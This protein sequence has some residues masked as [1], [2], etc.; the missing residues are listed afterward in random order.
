MLLVRVAAVVVVTLVVTAVPRAQ[1]GR[2]APLYAAY[3]RGDRAVVARA[4]RTTADYRELQ[5]D[6]LK[7]AEAWKNVRPTSSQPDDAFAAR[8]HMAFAFEVG[9]ARSHSAD[10]IGDAVRWMNIARELATLRPLAATQPAVDDEDRFE[11][12]VHRAAVVVLMT[13]P[14]LATHYLDT[15]TIRI[16][17]WRHRSGGVPLVAP[18]TLARGVA[19]ETRTRPLVTDAQDVVTGAAKDGGQATLRLDTGERSPS[20]QEQI[21]AA[22]STFTPLAADADVGAEA[23]VRSGLLW[24]RMGNQARALEAV[25][26][27]LAASRDPIV[28]YWGQMIRGRIMEAT[29]RLDDARTAYERA[30]TLVPTAQTP[31]VALAAILL[32]QNDRAG[33]EQW[34]ARARAPG[35]GDMRDPWWM[36]WFGDL[37]MLDALVRQIRGALS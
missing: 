22:L 31:A 28:S 20:E 6:L 37:R 5:D 10:G 33:A 16:D 29:N 25:D 8:N 18:L 24:H 14:G 32:V 7:L 27:G 1:S 35:V 26:R 21:R 11:V 3:A 17:V 13:S 30:A 15:L 36:Y 19:Y 12:L 2:A 9:L 34:A 4:L 23:D